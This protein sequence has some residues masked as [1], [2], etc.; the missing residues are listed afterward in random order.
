MRGNLQ[1]GYGIARVPGSIPARAGEPRDWCNRH[2][3][4]T[5]YPRAC[6]GTALPSS[7]AAH[8]AGLSPRVRGNPSRLWA[9]MNCIRS[10]PARAGEPVLPCSAARR[11]AVY[12]RACGGTPCMILRPYQTEGLSPRVRG[13]PVRLSGA[14]PVLGSIPARAGEPASHRLRWFRCWVYPRA[15]G[16][17]TPVECALDCAAGLS[18]RVR[19]NPR[20]PA[21]GRG[22]VRSIPARAGEPAPR[23]PLLPSARVYPRACGGTATAVQRVAGFLG[24]SPR[25]RGNR[26]QFSGRRGSFGSI[27]ARAG[28]PHA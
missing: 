21:P 14:S 4:G 8:N 15:C 25:V 27:P 20:N 26:Q 11:R 28:E 12:P 5:V 18:P 22:Q 3:G 9:S 16:G 19:G 23:P 2:F 10:I 24:L 13:N 6:G 17:T 1:Q 7:V